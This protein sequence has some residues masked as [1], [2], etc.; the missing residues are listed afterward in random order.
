MLV[1]MAM[2]CLFLWSVGRLRRA[3]ASSSG[4]RRPQAYAVFYLVFL[5]LPVLLLPIF[6]FNDS[7]YVALPL[8]GLTLQWWR[9]IVAQTGMHDA[10]VN[11]LIVGVPVAFVSTAVGLVAVLAL[12]GRERLP[13]APLITA[14]FTLPLVIPDII[15]GIAL[16][17]LFN[18]TGIGLSLLSVGFG[19]VLSLHAVCP[20]RADVALRGPRSEP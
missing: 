5:Y 4:S 8:K 17:I 18:Q 10:L 2:V 13:G 19:H 20:V 11:S 15:L 7:I 16:L 9:E 14:L 6:S 1:V 12:A 3:A